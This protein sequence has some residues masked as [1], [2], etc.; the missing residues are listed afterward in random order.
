VSLAETLTSAGHGAVATPGGKGQFDVVADGELV[1]SKH[2]L[3]RFPEEG[4]ILRLLD[5]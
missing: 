4:E 2:E 5:R 3:G 1:F